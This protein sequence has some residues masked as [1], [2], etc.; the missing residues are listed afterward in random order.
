MCIGIIT[1]IRCRAICGSRH[2]EPW[3]MAVSVTVSRANR[4]ALGEQSV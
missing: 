4:D 1:Y 2:P 3:H